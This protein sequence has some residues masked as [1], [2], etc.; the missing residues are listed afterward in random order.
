MSAF[1]AIGRALPHEKFHTAI[2]G[3]AGIVNGLVKHR[4]CQ[5]DRRFNPDWIKTID[6]GKL[7]WQ[8][9]C[10]CFETDASATSHG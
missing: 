3:G 7:G 10:T 2:C 9:S 8:K 4:D 5:S 1:K 6:P